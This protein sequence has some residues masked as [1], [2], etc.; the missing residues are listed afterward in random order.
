MQKMLLN[1]ILI[2]G[3]KSSRY[4]IAVILAW[5]CLPY[6][7]HGQQSHKYPQANDIRQGVKTEY[8]YRFA[9]KNGIIDDTDSTLIRIKHYNSLGLLDSSYTYFE[10]NQQPWYYYRHYSYKA[11]STAAQLYVRQPDSE[12]L[13]T[14]DYDS[15]KYITKETISDME[16]DSIFRVIDFIHS[17][18]YQNCEQIHR[19]SDGNE[20]FTLVSEYDEQ[21]NLRLSSTPTGQQIRHVYTDD[22]HTEELWDVTNVREKLQLGVKRYNHKMQLI[23]DAVTNT[24]AQ[25]VTNDGLEKLLTFDKWLTT[26]TYNRLGYTDVKMESKNGNLHSYVQYHYDLR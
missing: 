7:V 17:N 11:D 1:I 23:S 5:I 22:G 24:R 15:L 8:Q 18:N 19:D 12:A 9:I 20:L 26:L 10:R 13:Y 3:R 25:F 4:S 21:H 16:Q 6:K 2:I 14:F